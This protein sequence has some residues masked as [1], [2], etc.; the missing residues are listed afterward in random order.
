MSRGLSAVWNG[1]RKTRDTHCD[2]PWL[3][4]GLSVVGCA[5]MVFTTVLPPPSVVVMTVVMRNGVL[6]VGCPRLFVVVTTDM[7]C[8]VTLRGE[9]DGGSESGGE[10]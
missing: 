4:S 7:D 8:T 5:T 10:A 9:I 3:V 1:G 6:V 2:P